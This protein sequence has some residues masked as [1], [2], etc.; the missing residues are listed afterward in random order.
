LISI[1]GENTDAYIVKLTP[2]G[3]YPGFGKTM[4]KA[5]FEDNQPSRQRLDI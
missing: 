3:H 4:V 5:Y 2:C 1:D